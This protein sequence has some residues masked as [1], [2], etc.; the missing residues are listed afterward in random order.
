MDYEKM[1]HHNGRRGH[2]NLQ[3]VQQSKRSAEQQRRAPKNPNRLRGSGG[4]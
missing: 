1:D 3:R 2:W 4:E